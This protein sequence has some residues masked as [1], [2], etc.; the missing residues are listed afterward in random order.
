MSLETPERWYD[1][2][3]ALHQALD[4]LKQAPDKYQAQIA[5]NIIIII[6]EH[7][8]ESA[9]LTNV[10]ELVGFLQQSRLGQKPRYRRW[11]DVNETL[12]SALKLLDECPED[13]QHHVIPAISQMVESTLLSHGF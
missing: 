9:T 8:I 6:I 13:V 12:R 4:T 1:R 7:H 2:D 10:D 11:Y 3:P 5:L